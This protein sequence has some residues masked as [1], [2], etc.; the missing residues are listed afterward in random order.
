MAMPTRG[1]I[2]LGSL[3]SQT[4]ELFDDSSSDPEAAIRIED[5]G[6]QISAPLSRIDTARQIVDSFLQFQEWSSRDVI[7]AIANAPNYLRKRMC[8]ESYALLIDPIAKGQNVLFCLSVLSAIGIALPDQ[9]AQ[10]ASTLVLV[11]LPLI[12]HEDDEIRVAATMLGGV[13][14]CSINHIDDEIAN[15]LNQM[16]S[17]QMNDLSDGNY[18][19]K[20]CAW[21][22]FRSLMRMDR[23]L[24]FSFIPSEWHF[25]LIE[26]F[27][28]LQ[29]VDDVEELTKRKYGDS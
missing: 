25:D 12:N 22:F 14:M 27:L 19:D 6:D 23:E 29:E 3:L 8:P 17:S 24:F 4:R 13:V 18:D 1:G 26:I 5:L 28:A 7:W 15:F 20:V 10:I 2:V 9:M 21:R 11:L 16:I